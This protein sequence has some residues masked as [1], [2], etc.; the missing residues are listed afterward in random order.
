[1]TR[2]FDQV[3]ETAGLYNTAGFN[4]D[5]RAFCSIPVRH[6]V[7]RRASGELAGRP[8]RPRDRDRTRGGRDGPRD[9]PTTWRSGPTVSTAARPGERPGGR[10]ARTVPAVGL[11]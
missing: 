2:Y 1:M 10:A 5:T 4:D 7:W 11:R 8:R 3:I 6:D 9:P